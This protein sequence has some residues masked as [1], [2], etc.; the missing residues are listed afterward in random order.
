MPAPAT[1][2]ERDDVRSLVIN[3]QILIYGVIDS[4][5]WDGSIRAIDVIASLAELS[6]RDT[7]VVRINSPGGSVMEGLAIFNALRACGKKI[8]VRIDAMAASI[9]SVIAMAGD[10]II[11]ADN[12]SMM[13]HDVYG[14]VFG[15]SEDMRDMADEVDRQTQIIVDIYSKRTGLSPEEIRAMMS[16][17]TFLGAAECV[18]KGF[19]DQIAE[20]LRTAAYAPLKKEDLARILRA[21]AQLRAQS[22]APAAP[23]A[24]PQRG[25]AM[26]QATTTAGTIPAENTPAPPPA[27]APAAVAGAP[28]TVNVDQNAIRQEGVRAERERVATINSAV[29][30][31]RLSQDFADEMIR[32]GVT[33][34]DARQ[35]IIDK[36]AETQN[37]NGGT[38]PSHGQVTVV[39]DAQDKWRQGAEQGLLLRAGMLRGEAL[40][41]ARGN[42]FAG[43]TLAELA[44]SFL[45][46][47][48]VRSGQ[49]D[50]MAMIG[51]AFTFRNA[52]G[53]HSSSDF[54][55]VLG[56]VAHKAMMIGYQEAEE[57][58]DQW[59]AKG[60]ASDFRP[61]SRVDLNLFP[62]L[63][64]VEEGA[65]Y[66]YGTI[67]DTGVSVQ[68]ATYGKM[69]AITRQAI[70]N[71]D[72]SVMT[73]IPQRM[74]RAAK[75]TIGNLVYAILNSNP[76]MQDSV[77]LFNSAHGNLAASGGAPSVATLGAGRVAMSRQKDPDNIVAGL[78]LRPKFMLLPPELLDLALTIIN[79]EKTPGDAAGTPN[80]VRNI[81]TPVS[82]AR[83]AG[84]AWYFAA[85]PNAADTVEVTYLDGN[86]EPF[87]DQRE[88]WS[89]DGT[90]FKVRL[91]AGVKALHWRG[92]YK[93]PGA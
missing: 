40:Q 86:S 3:G 81:A 39:A 80:P 30:S 11:I 79:S 64:K 56:N 87:L 90:E 50:R 12:A 51:H 15:G 59:T 43:L 29:R 70:I 34:N 63:D 28:V 49:M 1:R 4:T 45:T 74:G 27:P 48:N 13:I 47:V 36:W 52:A 26:P 62:G 65:E 91:D 23:A 82:D 69:F 72:M 89:V 41:N 78:N 77:A 76:V 66:K 60:T 17:E 55:N 88:G 20:A 19:A 9:A 10:T 7:I 44:R 93:N 38:A 21:P 58:F 75:R 8:E 24:S 2:N 61:I 73:K 6:D 68:I 46:T 42:E 85:D 32:D 31:A 37:A 67:G 57:T 92:L 14:A 33:V 54:G 25:Q 71:D 16:Q 35:R 22:P 83:L 5:D 84:T 53:M 18:E